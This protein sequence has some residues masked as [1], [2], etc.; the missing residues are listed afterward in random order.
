MM[1]LDIFPSSG[2]QPVPPAASGSC[3][4]PASTG[5]ETRQHGHA[6][7]KGGPS[8]TANRTGPVPQ[9]QGE[10]DF[11]EMLENFLSAFEQEIHGC[12]AAEDE[13]VGRS[14]PRSPAGSSQ[15]ANRQLAGPGTP[16]QSRRRRRRRR[17]SAGNATRSKRS[18]GRKKSA[19]K[20]PQKRRGRKE[21]L[22]PQ[23]R[24]KGLA[25]P[26]EPNIRQPDSKAFLLQRQE[27]Q[28]LKQRPVVKLGRRGPLPDRMILPRNHNLDDIKVADI[29][30]LVQL[31]E[32]LALSL[33]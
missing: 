1:G 28:Q 12:G 23:P 4:Y 8:G 17:D 6:S 16:V 3:T 27:N 25:P 19:A 18:N 31:A 9:Q 32:L 20:E 21:H 33:R 26:S 14:Q 22:P 13:A 7:V 11:R 29:S 2:T 24:L 10:S 15:A 30:A 5:T